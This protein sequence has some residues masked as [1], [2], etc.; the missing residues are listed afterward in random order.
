MLYDILATALFFAS[1]L[2]PVLSGTSQTRLT[3][4]SRPRGQRKY[5]TRLSSRDEK[6]LR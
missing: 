2:M 3:V 6:Q 5:L 4:V 1:V